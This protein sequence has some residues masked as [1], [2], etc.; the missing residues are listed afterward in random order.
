MQYFLLLS[1]LILSLLFTSCENPS[2][3]TKKMKELD[4]IVLTDQNKI[5]EFWGYFEQQTNI[6]V[7]AKYIS[8]DSFILLSSEKGY[9]MD[10]DVIFMPS[11][12]SLL[13]L[14]EY[15]LLQEGIQLNNGNLYN[16]S[17]DSKQ[18]H[19]LGYNPYIT[20]GE[21]PLL[22]YSDLKANGNW[23]ANLSNNELATF[24]QFA[25]LHFKDDK[26]FKD[27]K[28]DMEQS[29]K[30]TTTQAYDSVPRQIKTLTL[31][32]K[33]HLNPHFTN[34]HG[35][36]MFYDFASLGIYPHAKNYACAKL[37]LEWMNKRKHL[38]KIAERLHLIPA[39]YLEIEKFKTLKFHRIT[40]KYLVK[41]GKSTA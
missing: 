5:A 23:T 17:D 25:Q 36:G 2:L 31:Y 3:Q 18:W 38:P 40:P 39:N 27:W 6:K 32:N 26:K 11:L 19:V 28:M 22:S 15:K 34:Q 7:N 1:G 35:A 20:S 4:L 12:N 16:A 10:A 41:L 9:N 14:K 30:E 24:Y 37:F 21:Q 29:R 13:A 8:V 33:E